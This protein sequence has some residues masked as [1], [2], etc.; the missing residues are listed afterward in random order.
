[1]NVEKGTSA[2]LKKISND[3]IRTNLINLSKDINL[4]LP[5]YDDRLKC[6]RV[7]IVD[8]KTKLN[9]LGEIKFN[10]E[11]VITDYTKISIIENRLKKEIVDKSE[12]TDSVKNNK[13]FYPT[14][15]PNKIIWGDSIKVLEDFPKDT[16][17]LIFT[18]PPY[19]NAKPEYS[20]YVDYQE[21]LDFLRRIFIRCHRIL[22][23]GRFIVINISPVLVK[24]TSRNTASKRIPIPFDIHRIL[25]NIGFEFIDDIMWVKPE[26]AGWNVGRGRRFAADRKPLQYKPVP[27]TEYILVYRKKTEK[28]IDWNLRNHYDSN[29]LEESKILGEYDRTNIWKIHPSHSKIHPATFP[30]ELAEKVIRYYSFK[31]DLVLD[32]FGGIGTVAKAAFKLNRRFLLI[33]NESKYYKHMKTTLK[34]IIPKDVRVDYEIHEDFKEKDPDYEL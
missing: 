3:W 34:K 21:Y 26:G 1:M 20:E 15:I 11:F 31:D 12:H 17:Q 30:E 28:L 10:N 25:D 5:E 18:S 27:V 13:L 33:E 29:L 16:A 6:W 23:E 19:Y 9:S 24:R 4:G 32:P 2:K 14:P 22:S 8:K 7:P